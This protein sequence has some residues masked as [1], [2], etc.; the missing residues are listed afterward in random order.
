M[1]YEMQTKSGVSNNYDHKASILIK[2]DLTHRR[3]RFLGSHHSLHYTIC[4]RLTQQLRTVLFGKERAKGIV[5]SLFKLQIV[6]LQHIKRFKN[7]CSLDHV[8]ACSI[9]VLLMMKIIHLYG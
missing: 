5:F 1:D 6:R 2:K 3:Y 9:V 8:L 7:W 4:V